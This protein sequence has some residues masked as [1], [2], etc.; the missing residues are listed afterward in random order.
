MHFLKY[1]LLLANLFV[2]VSAFAKDSGNNVIFVTFDGVRHQEFFGGQDPARGG[3][4]GKSVFPFIEKAIS[5]LGVVF[6]HQPS[7]GEMLASNFALLSLPAYQSIFTGK[8]QS[9]C[10]TNECSRVIEETFVERLLR[11]YALPRTQVATIASWKQLRLAVEAK[12][13][14]TFVNVGQVPLDDG[15]ID[16]TQIAI[17]E[18]QERDLPS[19]GTASRYDRYT[20]DHAKHYL[21]KHHPRFMY[22]SFNDSD[23][24]AHKGNY[25]NYIKSMEQDDAYIQ[26]LVTWLNHAGD[27]GR[28][29][30]LIV[31]TDHGRGSGS[32]WGDHGFWASESRPVW[33][34]AIGPQ[35]R[36]KTTTTKHYSQVK[37]NHLDIR[38][39]IEA[40]FGL[41][42]Q[43][44]DACGMPLTEIT[45][46]LK[47]QQAV[48]AG[49]N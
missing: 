44:C 27:Y 39:T 29:T 22:I 23:E 30:T 37:T 14:A 46:D 12:E 2:C 45:G 10:V 38:P 9:S 8:Y 33:M 7:G 41:T 26:E 25:P 20:F 31:T 43:Q 47:A 15:I 3:V 19:W 1:V 24:W 21:E 16:K 48:L 13:N 6:G 49:Q 36:P 42:P 34:F 4:K 11:E 35:V 18:Q 28:R 32:N 40:L 5:P 17:N